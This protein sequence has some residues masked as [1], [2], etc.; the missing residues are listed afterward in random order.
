MA[1]VLPG[2]GAASN[3]AA[4]FQPVQPLIMPDNVKSEFFKEGL[5]RAGELKYATAAQLTKTAIEETGATDRR[6]L[7]EAGALERL[8]LSRKM[9]KAQK[10]LALS[11]LDGGLTPG[12]GTK[13][14]PMQDLLAM[15]QAQKSLSDLRHK[16]MAGQAMILEG[17]AKGWPAP[18]QTGTGSTTDYTKLIPQ[19]TTIEV[20]P[21]A[22]TLEKK[23]SEQALSLKILR[24]A[25]KGGDI[26]EERANE[27]LDAYN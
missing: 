8:E 9:T 10:L 17:L 4:S 27:L 6:R 25:L 19:T 16:R 20:E 1:F 15:K 13:G 24:E 26:T 3:Y 22:S 5:R 11:K 23:Q 12:G 14:G 21:D 7:A 2:F 18:P